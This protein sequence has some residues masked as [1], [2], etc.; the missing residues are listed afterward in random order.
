M[1]LETLILLATLGL[2]LA[3]YAQRDLDRRGWPAWLGLD[4]LNLD[5]VATMRASL[6]QRA[7]LVTVALQGVEQERRAGDHEEA[8]ALHDLSTTILQ[9]FV[10]DVS[11]RLQQWADSA[12]ALSALYPLAPLSVLRARLARLRLLAAAWHVLHWILVSSGERFRLR[13]AMLTRSLRT[14]ARYWRSARPPRRASGEWRAPS[15]VAH[16]TQILAEAAADT[17]DALARSRLSH[18]AQARE[19]WVA[20]E[21]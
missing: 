6:R 10:Q 1:A 18:R 3:L 2:G 20:P 8:V 7:N 13:V 14:L 11:G 15:I 4:E 19:Q 5:G 9:T 12:R 17:Y 21:R 16:D